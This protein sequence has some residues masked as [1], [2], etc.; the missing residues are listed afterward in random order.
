M[1]YITKV[2]EVPKKERFLRLEPQRQPQGK[3]L[4]FKYIA[5]KEMVFHCLYSIPKVCNQKTGV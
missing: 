3:L 2:T 1:E 4:G 5:K